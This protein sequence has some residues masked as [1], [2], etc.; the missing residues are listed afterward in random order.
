M[1]NKNIIFKLIGDKSYNKLMLSIMI[2]IMNS[3]K[4]LE[5]V[6]RIKD[7]IQRQIFFIEN[8]N[9]CRNND[10]E[11][12]IHILIPK[13]RN[14]VTEDYVN[15]SETECLVKALINVNENRKLIRSVFNAAFNN[16]YEYCSKDLSICYIHWNE[17]L[18]ETFDKYTPIDLLGEGASSYI[19][20][21]EGNENH[22]MKIYIVK[23]LRFDEI[24]LC[25][26]NIK[27]KVVNMRREIDNFNSLSKTK[28]IIPIIDY[29]FEE[30]REYIIFEKMF[31][32][33]RNHDLKDFI[34]QLLNILMKIHNEG[35]YINDISYYN[36]LMKGDRIYLGDLQYVNKESKPGR[37][38]ELFASRKQLRGEKHSFI[39][40]FESIIYVVL[41][42]IEEFDEID[43]DDIME[44]GSN[45]VEINVL[46]DYYK[47]YVDGEINYSVF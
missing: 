21:I 17:Y 35:Y 19:F 6:R 28:V 2:N 42:F 46:I 16:E 44:N 12:L 40:E 31:Q 39:D 8:M 11:E 20:S 5:D 24:T 22:A 43:K 13:D 7:P 14:V 18:N 15:I 26:E 3:H 41:Y 45:Y 29:S 33:D 38:T 27:R 32:I 10:R 36:F 37:Y 9:L 23:V 4:I 25:T 34:K 30:H 1:I 47:N